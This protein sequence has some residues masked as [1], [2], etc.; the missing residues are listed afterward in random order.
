MIELKSL[1]SKKNFHFHSEKFQF[2][3]MAAEGWNFTNETEMTILSAHSF[4][5]IV[6]MATLMGRQISIDS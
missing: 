5:K 4:F 3:K 2:T 1:A 6:C